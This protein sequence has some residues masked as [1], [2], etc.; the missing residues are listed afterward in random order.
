M[1]PGQPS[2]WLVA[3]CRIVYQAPWPTVTIWPKFGVLAEVGSGCRYRFG[4][5]LGL[6]KMVYARKCLWHSTLRGSWTIWPNGQHFCPNGP[7]RASFARAVL[8]KLDKYGQRYLIHFDSAGPGGKANLRSAWIVRADEAFP[9][10]TC[11]IL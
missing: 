3:R 2:A 4:Q 5:L 10:F 8:G 9:R 1:R 7:R 11:Y 6:G